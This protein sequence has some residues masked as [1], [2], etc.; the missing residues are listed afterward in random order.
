MVDQRAGGDRFVKS[1]K[2]CKKKMTDELRASGIAPNE[3]S[4]LEQA[5]EEIIDKSKSA[6]QQKEVSFAEKQEGIDKEKET[7][8]ALRRRAIKEYQRAGLGKD[9]GKK[10]WRDK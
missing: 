3:P 9:V 6:E 1:E 4:E 10:G 7:A 2:A 5:L 8:E